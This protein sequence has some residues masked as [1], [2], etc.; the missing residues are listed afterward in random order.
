MYLYKCNKKH[1]FTHQTL[2]ADAS[3]LRFGTK[4]IV[5]QLCA[6]LLGN[7][8]WSLVIYLLITND[9]STN[10]QFTFQPKL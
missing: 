6:V 5:F 4:L 2:N 1:H 10:D 9:Q 7:S 3:V 8:H